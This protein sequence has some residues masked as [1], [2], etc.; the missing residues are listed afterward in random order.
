MSDTIGTSDAA[1]MSD[2]PGPT[3]PGMLAQ[4]QA[5]LVRA[6]V[7]GGEIPPGF[8]RADI[9]A[10]VKA[11]L[12]KRAEEVA[13]RY[14]LL[15]HECGPGFAAKYTAWAH[16]RPKISTAADAEAFAADHDLAS[17]RPRRR[18]RDLFR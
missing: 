8:D 12:H 15:A 2:P 14:P 11:L 1:G 7:A 13:A 3:A 10:T 5:A 18:L 6:L 16:A 9:T 4:Q 17:H